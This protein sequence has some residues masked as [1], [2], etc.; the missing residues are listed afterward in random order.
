MWAIC[1]VPRADKIASITIIWKKKKIDEKPF[2]NIQCSCRYL[3]KMKKKIFK[4]CDMLRSL[5]A[6]PKHVYE[7]CLSIDIE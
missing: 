2:K 7:A 6:F 1:L 4:W 3:I 5:T